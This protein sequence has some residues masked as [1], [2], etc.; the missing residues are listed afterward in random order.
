[1]TVTNSRDQR[2]AY[3]SLK[4]KRVLITG[5]GSG[6]GAGLVEGF[7][8]QGADVTFFDIAEAD[9]RALVESLSGEPQPPVFEPCDL[10]DVAGA[11]AKIAR[12]IEDFGAFDVLINNAANDDRHS[13]EEVTEAY[14]ENRINVNLKHLFF[15]AQAVI[16]GMKAKGAGVIINMGSISWHLALEGLILY[17]TAKAG[18]EGLTRS[19]ARDLGPDNIRSVCIVPGNVKT[20]RQMKWYTPEG[21]AEIVNAQCLKGRLVPEDIA[22]MALFL[23]SDDARLVTGHEYFVDAGWR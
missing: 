1:M 14:W 20:P 22:A 2:A 11:Q 9:S 8:R 21:E 5:G 13:I 15:C 7:V 4:G 19:M 12:L 3:P 6:I 18:I 23:A 17:Q 16:P 10:T